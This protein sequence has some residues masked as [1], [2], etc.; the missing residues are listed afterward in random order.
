VGKRR[1]KM[2]FNYVKYD[3]D[4]TKQQE[5]VKMVCEGLE[6]FIDSLGKGRA[7][8]LAMTKLEEMYMWIGKAIRDNQVE[9]GSQPEH[10]A[11]RTDV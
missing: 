3:E 8:S 4:S 1:N 9:R 10:I 6:V 5:E 2:R 11:E 7:Q